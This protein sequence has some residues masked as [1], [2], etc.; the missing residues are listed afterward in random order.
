M[1]IGILAYQGGIDEHRYMIAEACNELSIQCDV[2]NVVKRSDVNGIDALIIP[3]GESTTIL[4]LM[5]KFNIV[6]VLKERIENGLPVMGT[7][8][9]AILLAKKVKDLKTGR[10][11]SGTLE[12]LDSLAIRN[13]YG[14]QRES[15]EVDLNIPVIGDKPFRAVF[16][17]APAIVE[18]GQ[19]VDVLARYGESYVLVKQS[20]ILASTFHPELSGDARLHKY[21]IEFVKR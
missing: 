16:I 17:R 20:E 1:R 8:A 5:K 11:M 14:R 4:K 6:E 10:V 3:G 19:G 13:Y 21:F 9:G 7:C 2:V 12:V 15:F 18:V